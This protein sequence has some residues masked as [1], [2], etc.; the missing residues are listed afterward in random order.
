MTSASTSSSS[1]GMKR[2]ALSIDDKLRIIKLYDETI[3]VF[4]KQQIADQLGLPFSSL[5]TILKNRKEIEKNAFSGSTKRQKVRN[6][7][8]EQL[9]NI[10]LEWFRQA[11]TL[12]LAVNGPVLT[13]KANEIAKRLNITDFGGSNGWLDRFRKRHGIVYRKIC[14]EADAVDDNSIKSWKET[15]QPNFLKDYSPEDIYNAD[16]FGLFFKL[17]PD[18]SLVMKDETCHGGKLSKDRLTVLTCSNWSGTDKL[19]LLLKTM[20]GLLEVYSLNGFNSS[21][22]KITL[23]NIKLVFFPPNATSKL[24]PLDQGVIKVLKQKYCKKLVQRYLLEM[25]SVTDEEIPKIPKINVLDAIH[26]VSIAWD[27]IKPE[28]I[29]NCFN[30]AYFGNVSQ[31]DP[32]FLDSDEF[33]DFEE[34]NPGYTSIDDQLITNEAP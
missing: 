8:N 4:N 29:K 23:T 28:V 17:M 6:G 22:A 9:E 15:I 2:K 33:R 12:N 19:K 25:E 3:G 31:E 7:K 32:H 5:R 24:Q 11:R 13:E 1:A 30:K 26:Y 10:L 21:T 20:R 34:V 16:E 27:E 14:G 18:K